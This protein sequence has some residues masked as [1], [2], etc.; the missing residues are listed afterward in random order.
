MSPEPLILLVQSLKRSAMTIFSLIALFS[1][2]AQTSSMNTSAVVDVILAN[3]P[4]LPFLL[5][6]LQILLSERI[7]LFRQYVL[8]LGKP[9]LICR[10]FAAFTARRCRALRPAGLL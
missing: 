1:S 2:G 3:L 4:Y 6:R 5:A 8:T 10:S 9:F 7:H